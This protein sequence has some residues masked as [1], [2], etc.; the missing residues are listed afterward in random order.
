LYKL[1]GTLF[2]CFS[3]SSP[4]EAQ[5]EKEREDDLVDEDDFLFVW[6]T[7]SFKI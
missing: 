2:F 6:I 5:K 3:S 7:L 4:Q 1:N